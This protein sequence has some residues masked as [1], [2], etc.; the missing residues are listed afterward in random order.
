ME[1]YIGYAI[2]GLLILSLV[3]LGV[4]IPGGP[5]ENRNFSHISP[6]ILGLFNSFLTALG[7]ASLPTAYF[8][9]G[10]SDTALIIATVCGI[11]YFLVYAFDLT[12]IFPVS[13][14]K[15]PRAL[16]LIEVV[17][18]VV[19]IPLTF[20]PLYYLSIPKAGATETVISAGATN[21]IL[22]LMLILG[23]GIVIFATR[24]AMRK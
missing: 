1:S 15:M 3:L 19:S 10:G 5:I 21:G 24:A 14:D 6:I 17:G 20:L 2:A 13:P 18:L 16:F 8:S 22:T 11:S 12:K 4:L 7:I 23:A 9:I